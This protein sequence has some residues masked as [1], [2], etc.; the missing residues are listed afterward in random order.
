MNSQSVAETNDEKPIKKAKSISVDK[1]KIKPTKKTTKLQAPTSKPVTVKI[2]FCNTWSN[3][4]KNALGL[5]ALLR[6]AH[7]G[8]DLNFKFEPSKIRELKVT[9]EHG[10]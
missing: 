4:K 7:P 2:E 8:F 3:I 1:E 9:I 6:E 10:T 5:E